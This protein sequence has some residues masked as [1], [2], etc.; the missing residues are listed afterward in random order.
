M[1]QK[2]I[3]SSRLHN[4]LAVWKGEMHKF[5]RR[6]VSQNKKRL[7]EGQYDL[8][9]TY[10]KSNIIAMQFP[11]VG[12]EAMYRNSRYGENGVVQYLESRHG[13]HYR[14]YNLCQEK[15]YQYLPAV[16]GGKLSC[17]P[18]PDHNPAP[19]ILVAEFISDAIQFLHASPK[20]VVVVHCKA[21]RGR[22]CVH[23]SV[24]KPVF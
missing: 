21:G 15:Q 19:L 1:Q 5:L 9:L 24:G 8:D 22:Q 7:I 4:K 17:Y 12:I 20:N 2:I 11:A 13:E 10:I 3:Y 16:F 6:R 23:I 14:V 18:F